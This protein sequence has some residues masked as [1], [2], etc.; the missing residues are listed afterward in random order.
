M[1]AMS[2]VQIG[3]VATSIFGIKVRNKAVEF[4]QVTVFV[5]VHTLSII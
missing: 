5:H 4:N 3:K 1:W 2:G